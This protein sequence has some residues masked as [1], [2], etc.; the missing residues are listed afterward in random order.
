MPLENAPLFQE[1]GSADFARKELQVAMKAAQNAKFAPKVHLPKEKETTSATCVRLDGMHLVSR[2]K[3]VYYVLL[4][5]PVL[6]VQTIP[7][8]VMLGFIPHETRQVNVLPVPLAQ[9]LQNKKVIPAIHANQD[10]L[11]KK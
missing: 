4:E 2:I 6:A 10:I 7:K 5:R 9:L 1:C 3:N 11:Q 8:S